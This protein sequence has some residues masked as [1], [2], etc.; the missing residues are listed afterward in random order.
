MLVGLQIATICGMLLPPS[1]GM[2]A[3]LRS[4]VLQSKAVTD[5]AN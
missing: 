4:G 1:N 3:R 2:I 5:K